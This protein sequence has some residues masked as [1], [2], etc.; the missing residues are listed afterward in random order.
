M[1]AD[2][3]V[4]AE[5]VV[6][7][8]GPV[9]L[10]LAIQLAQRGRSVVVVERWPEPYPLPRAVHFDHEVG[11]ILQSCG[12]GDDL[13][14]ISEPA[15]IYEWRNADGLVLLRFGRIGAASSG[16]PES[17][18]FCQPEF[19][20]LL[21]ERA[22]SLDGLEIRRGVA[23]SGLT[24][25]DDGVDVQL[26]D[27]SAVGGR[28]V[29]GCDGANSTVRDLVGLGVVDL[30]FFY[31]WLIVDVIL[32]E[33]RVF[34][35]I[36]LQICDPVRPTTAV[37][38]G[39]GRRRWE[40][41]CLPEENIEDFDDEARAWE[42]LEDWDVRPD[43]ARLERHAVYTFQARY[44]EDWRAGRVFLA[45]DAAHQM[46]PFAGQ[47]MCSGIRDAANLAWKLD[48]VLGGLADDALL[49]TY[50]TERLP[51]AKQAIDFS[52]GL[53]QVICV[54]DPEEA[55][56]RDAAMAADVTDAISEVPPFPGIES[57]IVAEDSP[58]HG[59]LF[60]Q[61]FDQGR[62]FDDVHGVGWRL[63]TT[64]DPVDLDPALVE[65]FGSIG[66]LVVAAPTD[67]PDRDL[68]SWFVLHDVAWALERPDFA[69]YGTATDA[70]G[71]SAL[72][73]RLRGQLAAPEPSGAPA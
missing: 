28:Y 60:P 26:E 63:V 29:V 50:T 52:V 36:N 11:R 69:L 37:S 67:A 14:A 34:D 54:P 17:S 66:G 19:E 55:A 46:P 45:G 49:D 24:Q 25:H 13:R 58:H 39:P 8:C 53:G 47:G 15:E 31:D 30:G 2:G 42:L 21:A 4:D 5:V 65:W 12:L 43:N 57:G 27:G 73:D 70:A 23:V 18:M 41:M 72:L 68:V 40:F 22:E 35:P 16:W 56:A 33:E 38:G 10:T 59:S 3:A 71:A 6:V 7:G 9:G 44:A 61:G 62:P 1:T 64:D 51:S 32:D 48:L 20:A